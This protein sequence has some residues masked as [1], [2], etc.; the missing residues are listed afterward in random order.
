MGSAFREEGICI[1]AGEMWGRGPWVAA[2]V[3]RI[4]AGWLRTSGLSS[5]QQEPRSDHWVPATHTLGHREAGP[6]WD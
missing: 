6:K 2:G 1:P 4:P 5:H 3:D